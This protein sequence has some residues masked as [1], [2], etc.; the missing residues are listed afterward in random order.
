[1]LL[2]NDGEQ[3]KGGLGNSLLDRLPKEELDRLR[4]HLVPIE[5]ATRDILYERNE[6]LLHVY[7]PRR[8]CVSLVIDFDDGFQA[9]AG[10][11]GSEGMV[12]V[13]LAHGIDRDI[14]T[15]VI[16]A[17]SEA[18]R[19]PASVFLRELPQMPEFERLLMRYSE[20][21]R[22]QAMQLAACNGH[23]TLDERLARC[24]LTLHD[25]LRGE[26]LPITQELLAALL[27]AHRP[28]VSLA[29]KRLRDAA[30]IRTTS[31]RVGVAD[32]VGLETACCECYQ[33]IREHTSA[34]LGH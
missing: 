24:L 34:V 9:E 22:T 10:L 11:V 13:P 1:M 25:R 12:G 16:Q 7:F 15:A 31:G 8:G 29:I 21:M 30:L 28:S 4:S 14:V 18:L 19:L 27:C 3:S 2:G 23:H 33:I 32:R 20:A 6:K 26:D 5:L 17:P